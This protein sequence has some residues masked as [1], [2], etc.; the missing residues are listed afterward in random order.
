M[1]L[2]YKEECVLYVI[3]DKRVVVEGEAVV[4]WQVEVEE[5]TVGFE[6]V[7]EG[8]NKKN[9]N[10]TLNQHPYLDKRVSTEIVYRPFKARMVDHFR[11]E[12]PIKITS[13]RQ[14]YWGQL[15]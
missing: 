10:F 11:L 2:S 6:L 1:C 4:A 15:A 13:R 7:F 8:I 3:C 5:W 9:R 14:G 12:L